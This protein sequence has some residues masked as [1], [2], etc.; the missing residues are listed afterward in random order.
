M[1][2]VFFLVKYQLRSY[3]GILPLSPTLK[4]TRK[5][6]E[7]GEGGGGRRCGE[8]THHHERYLDLDWL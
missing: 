8:G 7:R 2:N 1:I 4:Y 6:I 3:I 5:F